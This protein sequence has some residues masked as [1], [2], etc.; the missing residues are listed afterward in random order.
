MPS[1]AVAAAA[2]AALSPLER[3][4]LI[5][6]EWALLLAGLLFVAG[7]VIWERRKRRARDAERLGL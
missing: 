1:K 3:Y 2:P 6:D 4:G 5:E 7:L